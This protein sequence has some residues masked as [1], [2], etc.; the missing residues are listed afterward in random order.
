MASY[1]VGEAFVRTRYAT[2]PPSPML[3]NFFQSGHDSFEVKGLRAE[4]S[5][6]INQNTYHIYAHKRYK[7][8]ALHGFAKTPY[9]SSV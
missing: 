5:M 6:P 2:S 4:M 3:T 1:A 9:L 8:W 7:R